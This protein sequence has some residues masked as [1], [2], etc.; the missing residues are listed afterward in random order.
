MRR[1]RTTRKCK[2]CQTF[3]APDSRSA[4]RQRYCSMPACQKASK[5]ASQC[6]WLHK[7]HNR[8]YCRGP[9]PFG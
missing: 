2:H 5:A 6:R 7:P 4:K 9:I 8:D 1:P 3:F